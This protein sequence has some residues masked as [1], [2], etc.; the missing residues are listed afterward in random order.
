M[1]S[2]GV[3]GHLMFQDLADSASAESDGI[4][5]EESAR[6]TRAPA[7]TKSMVAAKSEML[8]ETKADILGSGKKSSRR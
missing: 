3:F 2:I 6:A 8:N 4:V 7:A 1:G 5:E